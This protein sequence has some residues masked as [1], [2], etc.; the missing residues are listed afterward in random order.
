MTTSPTFHLV[1]GAV[2]LLPALV[3]GI[4][5][6]HSWRLR[7]DLQPKSPLLLVSSL[8]AAITAL[9]FV[10]HALLE[11]TP[12]EV[13]G[14]AAGLHDVVE[15]AIAVFVVTSLALF[16][17]MIPMLA[18]PEE[19]R[20]T[21]WLVANYAM[22]AVAAM[23]SVLW[24][25]GWPSRSDWLG[26]HVVPIGFALV[27]AALALR[28]AYRLARRGVWRA[29]PGVIELRSPDV[30]VMAGAVA[31]TGALLLV[32][33]LTGTAA[34]ATGSGLFAHTTMGLA[35][36]L[37]FV[38]R[39]FGRVVR[40]FLVAVAMIA[41]TAAVYGTARAVAGAASPEGARLVE[42]AAVGVLALGL[43]PARTW[44]ATA[45]ERVVFRRGDRRQAELQAVLHALSPESGVGGCCQQALLALC[46]V[47]RLRGAAV[48]LRDGDPIVHGAFDPRP[49]VPVWPRGAASD[50]LPER[51]FSEGLLRELAP[52]LREALAEA[53]VVTVVPIASRRRRWGHLLA[54]EGLFTTPSS[55]EDAEEIAGFVAQLAVL[56]DA[57]EL[58]ARAVA[59]ERS[60]AHAE[61]LA[62]I[63]ETAARIAHDIRNPVAA[64]RSLAQ[65]LA[66][67]PGS[68]FRSEHTLI[69]AELDRVERH[70]A[71]LLRFARREELRLGTV[72]L[73]ELARTT[74]AHLGSRL[75]RDGIAV[76]LRLATDVRA[77]ADVE[78]L[79]QVLIN[80]LENAAD[81]LA[82]APNGRRLAVEVATTGAVATVRVSDSGPGVPPAALDRL[83]EPFFS[84]KEH[85]TGLGLA[86][87]KRTIDAHGGRITA[88]SGAGMTF[89]I[90]L[91]LAGPA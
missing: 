26:P 52:E 75:A 84:L 40:T 8:I 70:V 80:L 55:S 82:D 14:R 77:R 46:R 6:Y 56:L 38:V 10:L 64:A 34:P 58:V 60:L 49:L 73:G 74:V 48:F 63:G 18:I 29:G 90:E 76:D 66:A 41:V 20:R 5:A 11:L 35:L 15:S 23:S 59:V 65:Q 36:A 89:D 24:L 47:M 62:A 37:P 31:L 57:A 25:A 85:G 21:G 27:M 32:M 7:R 67:E 16:R 88:T 2:H 22:A 17:H 86:I 78:K 3:W 81:A 71:A 61:K 42:L 30:I 54:T 69:L 9:H 91:P 28:H 53:Q 1:A 51:A 45:I 33:V 68:P 39:M 87:A 19:P 83:F 13:D 79:R 43:V 44:L 4:V 12:R 50:A 72:D